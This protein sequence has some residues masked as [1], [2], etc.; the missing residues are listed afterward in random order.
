MFQVYIII[1]KSE[2][3]EKIIGSYWINNL[4]AAAAEAKYLIE[5]SFFVYTHAS[6]EV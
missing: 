2:E 1:F 5:K 6:E 3:W 4:N